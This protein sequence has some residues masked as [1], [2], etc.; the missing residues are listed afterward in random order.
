MAQR[1]KIQSKDLQASN[2]NKRS[3]LLADFAD[4][5]AVSGFRR[6]LKC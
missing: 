1:L 3:V 6:I 5:T 2:K 4:S